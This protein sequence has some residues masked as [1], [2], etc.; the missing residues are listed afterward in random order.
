MV[1]LKIREFQ[2]DQTLSPLPS[3]PV[4][5]WSLLLGYTREQPLSSRSSEHKAPGADVIFVW[6]QSLANFVLAVYI[7]RSWD[8]RSSWWSLIYW[9]FNIQLLFN[10]HTH[11]HLIYLCVRIHLGEKNKKIRALMCITTFLSSTVMYSFLG[12]IYESAR[13]SKNN[14]PKWIHRRLLIFINESEKYEKMVL[15][16][17]NTQTVG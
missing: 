1:S 5:A 4:A 9:L 6:Y 8:F 17:M 14:S 11:I 13:I 15:Y 12:R 10:T 3:N 2:I 16:F 7:E